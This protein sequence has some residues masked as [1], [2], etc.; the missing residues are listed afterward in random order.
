VRRLSSAVRIR[1]ILIP[2]RALLLLVV[3]LPV[4][5]LGACAPKPSTGNAAGGLNVVASFYP[6]AEAARQAGG[7]NVHVTDLTPPGVEP[8]DL[9]LTSKQVDRVQD[10]DVVLLLDGDFQ[11]AVAR[12]AR[13]SKGKV[14]RIP[15]PAD[16]PHIW[17]DPVQ[18]K[19]VVQQVAQALKGDPTTFTAALDRLDAAYGA[20][21][22]DCQ[23]RV[24]VTAHQAFGHLARRYGLTQEAITG[25]S[26]EAE[27]DP[28][29]LAA[30]ADLVKRTGTTTIFTEELVSPKVA[31]ALA[32]EA[33]VKTDVLNPLESGRP[34]DAVPVMEDNL[35]RMRAALGCR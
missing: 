11:P 21:L 29:R 27:P 6:L 13:R 8:H 32:R 5:I 7:P 14:V 15:V 9:E 4:L 12:A 35:R 16:D 3:L 19:G 24:L 20:G 34:G 18:M 2:R 31:E 30:L 1:I 22:A 23:R 33:G 17:L 28:R 26:P 25:I 10:A